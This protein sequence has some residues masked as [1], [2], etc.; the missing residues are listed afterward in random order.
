[1]NTTIRTEDTP[2]L[3]DAAR[4]LDIDA[5]AYAVAASE[6][7]QNRLEWVTP[8]GETPIPAAIVAEIAEAFERDEVNLDGLLLA[9]E[10]VDQAQASLVE[11]RAER[12][13][14]IR[15]ARKA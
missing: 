1:M 9:A 2:T 11:A 4:D 10:L 13:L 12:D 6:I 7:A 15:A 14:A 5:A 3:A 8:I